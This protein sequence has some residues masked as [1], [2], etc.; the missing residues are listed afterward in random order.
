MYNL[1]CKIYRWK[2]T[3]HTLKSKNSRLKFEICVKLNLKSEKLRLSVNF[4]NLKKV[5]F[6]LTGLKFTY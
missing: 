3:I 5:K 4:T 6:T 1:K 2:C